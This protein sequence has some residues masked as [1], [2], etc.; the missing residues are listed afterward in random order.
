MNKKQGLLSKAW[1]YGSQVISTLW[2]AEKNGASYFY[3]KNYDAWNELDYLKAFL[4]I[5]E[6]NAVISMDAKMFGNGI[7]KE[8]DA[9][10][11]ET[12]NSKLVSA[13]NNP[14]WFQS[15]EEFRRQTKLWRDIFGNEY[16]YELVPIGFDFENA[17]QRGLF[18]LPPNWMKVEYTEQQPFFTFVETPDGVKYIICYN[19]NEKELP[20][21]SIIHLNDDRVVMDNNAYATSTKNMLKGTSK[22]KAL[23]PALNNLRMAYETRGTM[24][25]NRGALG[26]LSNATSDKVGAIPLDP[27]ETKTL[28]KQYGKNYGGLSG[29]Y[30]LLITNSDLRW[31]QM[32]VNPDKMGLYTE[33][34]EDFNK[35]IDAYGS[36]RDL[37]AG[38]D[39]TFENQKAAEKSVYI[40]TIIP[41]AA[42]WIAGFN[43]KHRAGA[44]TK[45]I[46]DYFYLPIF[47]EDLAQRG[48]SLKA[49][50]D[51]LSIALTDKAIDIEQY[52][53]ELEK[54]GIK[55]QTLN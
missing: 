18:T 54:F 55:T 29:Q 1:S 43:K 33:T 7:I 42:E 13:L 45:L 46:M 50:V 4:G 44:R 23:T 35:I 3:S 16:L 15:G 41:N 22:I 12:K 21:G 27:E 36:K 37:F 9:N 53:K 48:E 24:L 34:A 39:V 8:V 52:K 17:T 11:V 2:R 38:K 14:N 49:N 30:Q 47:Q 19:N 25:K 40:N 31:Q 10:G 5:P 20:K 6:L 51:A 26:I 28:Q 32:S